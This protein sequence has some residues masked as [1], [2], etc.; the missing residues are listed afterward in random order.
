[1]QLLPVGIHLRA[2]A[3]AGDRPARGD[4]AISFQN[5]ATTNAH[6]R[7]TM[8]EHRPDMERSWIASILPRKGF[9]TSQPTAELGMMWENVRQV[10]DAKKSGAHARLAAGLADQRPE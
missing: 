1:M 5:N 7:S 10:M 6:R 8:W 3:A 4:D 9:T 2:L